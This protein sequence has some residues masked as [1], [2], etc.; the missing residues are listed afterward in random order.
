VEVA[1]TCNSAINGKRIVSFIGS[2][3]RVLPCRQLQA[4]ALFLGQGYPQRS[5]LGQTSMQHGH[6]ICSML[7]VKG[8]L[9][10]SLQGGN[11]I[12]HTMWD[13]DRWAPV[14]TF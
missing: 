10:Q 13:E 11:I 5:F 1:T 14:K 9:V 4:L 12:A 6:D 3:G 7:L 2:L 8:L